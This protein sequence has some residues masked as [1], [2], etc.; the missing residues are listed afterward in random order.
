MRLPA[1]PEGRLEV[2]GRRLTLTS[3]DRLLWPDEGFTKRDLIAYYAAVA[4]AIVPQLAGRPLTMASFPHGVDGRG[5]LQNECRGAPPW[6][7]TATLELRTGARRR[8][9]IVDDAA[10]L[11]W[12]A[13]LGTIEFHPYPSAAEQPDAPLAVLFDIDRGPGTTLPDACRV[14][15]RLR[16]RLTADGLPALVKTSGA[17]GLHVSAPVRG[18]DFAA[19]RRYARGVAASLAEALPELVAD[20]GANARR[21][22]RLLIDW[23][24][25]DPRRSTAAA[26]SLRATI[27][28]GVSTPLRWDEVETQ[29]ARLHHSPGGVLERLER[30]GDLYAS[31]PGRLP[32]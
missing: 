15:L 25:N 28:A 18:A 13:N 23:R 29:P 12:V 30:Y 31:S 17:S 2:G 9:C 16:T 3:L 14:A 26:Y 19:V 22:D 4:P 24:Q 5:F 32:G 11:L 10:S 27:P 21:P 1:G 6:L 20:P 8:Y 7:R